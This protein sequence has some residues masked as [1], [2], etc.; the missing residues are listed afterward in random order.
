M[1]TRRPCT[2]EPWVNLESER[3]FHQYSSKEMIAANQRLRQGEKHHFYQCV[4]DM[5]KANEVD[6]DYLEFGCH[7]VRTF[8]MA[9]TEARRQG[10][11]RMRFHAFDSFEGLPP[12]QSDHGVAVYRPKN[13]T[14]EESTF[15]EIVTEHGIYTD[16]IFTH[17]GFYEHSLTPELQ[18]RLL[19]EGIKASLICIDC[20]L[21]ASTTC[22]FNFIEPFL[23]EGTVI[24]IDD[25]YVAYKGNPRRGVGRTWLDFA[26][27]LSPKWQ[28]EPFL[29]V[30][31]WGK[32][33]IAC[34]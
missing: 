17:K 31:W 21:I 29:N 13:L 34:S 24:Y 20:D 15:R 19:Q 33:Y 32:S 6:G 7:R 28:F 12:D 30:G 5:I 4:F 23:Q 27:R 26:E 18:H 11:D 3:D 1:H 8:R 14:T 2:T 22:V 25:Y 9:L 16:R 10:L